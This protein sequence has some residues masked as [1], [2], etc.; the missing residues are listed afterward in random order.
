MRRAMLLA[1]ALH[2]AGCLSSRYSV[3][4]EALQQ[5]AS[6][7]PETRWQRVRV[8]QGIGGDEAPPEAGVTVVT[9]DPSLLLVGLTPSPGRS[10]ANLAPPP[11]RA[12]GTAGGARGGGGGGGGG[13]GGA[14]VVAAVVVA[15]AAGALVLAG[16]EGARYDGWVATHPDEPVYLDTPNGTTVVPLSQ[17]TPG[18]AAQ[19]A[20][21][22]LYEG[23]VP[24]FE[25]RGRAP[26]D[27][28]GF[29]LQSAALAGEIPG[30]APGSRAWAF[31]GRAFVGGFPVA[32]LGAGL[33]A[34][35]T[36]SGPETLVRVGVEAQAMPLLWLGAFAG[37]G[38]AMAHR[39]SPTRT[40][41]APWF[42]AGL[43]LELP[44]TTR[45]SVQTRAG[46]QWTG[47]G[48]GGVWGPT[49]SLGLSI[50]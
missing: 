7:P 10:I 26:L 23:P 20:G 37:G 21:G 50:Y 12:G 32:Q 5:L 39:A 11:L 9:V 4:A 19:A 33:L 6:Q 17:L 38:Y 25:R 46:A 29:T 2:G 43:Q 44:W 22:S 45:L 15:A 34:D 49:F 31:G 30:S 13:R 18:L 41:G 16:I 35:V 48:E 47:L 3:R 8:V 40:D 24:R 42:H 1:V 36:T 27:R 14:W 28:V